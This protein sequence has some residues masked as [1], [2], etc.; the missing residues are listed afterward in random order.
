MSM[1]AEGTA[2]SMGM[3]LP[4]AAWV[5]AHMH[6]SLESARQ[7]A[8]ANSWCQESSRARTLPVSS[9]D[10]ILPEEQT[11]RMSATSPR[12]AAYRKVVVRSSSCLA[13]C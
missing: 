9:Q 4:G 8:G 13:V 11:C 6:Q 5:A 10:Y 1:Q 12:V 3:F 2:A 7:P